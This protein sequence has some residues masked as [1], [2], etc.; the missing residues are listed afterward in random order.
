MALARAGSEAVGSNAKRRDRAMN[1]RVEFA[2][3]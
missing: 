1:R 2:K 3:L